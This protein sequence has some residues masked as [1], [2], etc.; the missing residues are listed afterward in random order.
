MK[1]TK[2]LD[3]HIDKNFSCYLGDNIDLIDGLP[4]N[5]VGLTVTSVPFPQ[6][7]TYSNSS[8]DIGNTNGVQQM[9]DHYRYLAAPSKLGRITKPGRSVCI[10]LTNTA[11]FKHHDGIVG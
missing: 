9:L 1:G 4:D 10:H 8:R 7:W 3:Q 11:F 6:M 5:S 2:V